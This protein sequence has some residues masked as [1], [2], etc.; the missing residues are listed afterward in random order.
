MA[1]MKCSECGREISDKAEACPQ[2]GSPTNVAK[3]SAASTKNNGNSQDWKGI[4]VRAVLVVSWVTF[5][6]LLVRLLT[7]GWDKFDPLNQTHL[8]T[9][10]LL[11]L[12]AGLPASGCALV[13]YF[14]LNPK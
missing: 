5:T 4:I 14:I 11:F 7:G 6:I 13:V 8:A 2:C 9:L 10:L 1:L 12:T 3:R